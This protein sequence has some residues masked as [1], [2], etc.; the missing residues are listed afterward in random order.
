[1]PSRAIQPMLRLE[2]LLQ[3]KDRPT[4]SAWDESTEEFVE[5]F[6]E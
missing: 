1:M 5:E 2:A 6:V 3:A 4:K